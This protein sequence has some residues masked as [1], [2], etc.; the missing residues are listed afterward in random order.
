[1]GLFD[2]L[3]RWLAP[4]KKAEEAQ[5]PAVRI[6][7]RHS[8][9]PGF[10]PGADAAGAIV[11]AIADW[12][13]EGGN[14]VADRLADSLAQAGGISVAR[15]HEVLRLA[16]AGGPVERLIQ[17]VDQGRGWLHDMPADLLLWGEIMPA[18]N[19]A[20]Y[21]FLPAYAE[22]D[23]TLG[24]FGL[25]DVIEAPV[26]PP[27]LAVKAIAAT[28]LAAAIR[29]RIGPKAPALA[30][31]RAL[32]AEMPEPSDN[33]FQP[34]AP[35]QTASL[36]AG[37]GHAVAA[38]VRNGGGEKQ[39]DL[40]LAYYKTAA[41]LTPAL[42]ES[43][44]WSVAEN[45]RANA[46]TAIAERDQAVAPLAAA[47]AAYQ[48]ITQTLTKAQFP[49]DWALAQVRLGGTLFRLGKMAGKPQHFREAAA[50]YEQALTVFTH[51][52][53]PLRWAELMNHYGVLLTALGE[54]LS[55]TAALEQAVMVFHKA[56][57]VRRRET[58]PLLWAQTASNLGTAAFA[59]AKRNGDGAALREA[60]ACFEGAAEIYAQNGQGK[61]AGVLRKNLIRVQRLIDTRGQTLAEDVAPPAAKAA[62][63]AKSAQTASAPPAAQAAK[64][65]DSAKA[66][67][68]TKSAPAAKK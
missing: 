25:G 14:L 31:L 53:H 3:L 51:A 49:V 63:M 10:V 18:H 24:A 37:I 68:T 58:M 22:P 30:S 21:R 67:N 34:L 48:A 52:A 46:L 66:A 29:A 9:Q 39:L 16:G 41:G 4:P 64:T 40:A 27:A 33:A 50:A 32:L 26:S 8:M 5:K 11:V 1:M 2:A 38:D 62:N 42:A 19:T 12:D 65:S 54:Y 6:E 57:D 43:L 55:G 17:A 28:T 45:H 35:L 36:L 44:S 13:G 20:R 15:R 23:G 60:A 56:L 61:A 47:A 7:R 59:L